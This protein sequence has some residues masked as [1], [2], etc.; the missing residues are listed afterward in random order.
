LKKGTGKL[1]GV[2]SWPYDVARFGNDLHF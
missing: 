1:R 2:F